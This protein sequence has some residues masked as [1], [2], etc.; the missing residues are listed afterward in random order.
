MP[1]W[2]H[3][4]HASLFFMATAQGTSPGARHPA[5]HQAPPVGLAELS[6][7]DTVAVV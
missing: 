6:T 2:E 1:S 4:Y 7:A 3:T 5:Q